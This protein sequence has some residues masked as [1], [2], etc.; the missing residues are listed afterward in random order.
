VF[1]SLV[2]GSFLLH[3]AAVERTASDATAAKTLMGFIIIS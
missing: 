1:V 3:A 2:T